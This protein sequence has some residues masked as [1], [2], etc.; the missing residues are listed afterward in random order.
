MHDIELH[1]TISPDLYK[2]L[3]Y[4][5]GD[6]VLK[7]GIEK[8]VRVAEDKQYNTKSELLKIADRILVESELT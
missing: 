6:G 7:D 8:V 3:K 2:K 5:Y 4:K 1:T